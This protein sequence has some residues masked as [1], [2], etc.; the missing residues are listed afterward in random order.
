M[1][2]V[3][4]LNAQEENFKKQGMN[5]EPDAVFAVSMGQE[6]AEVRKSLEQAG[7]EAA[8]DEGINPAHARTIIDAVLA[9]FDTDVKD[10]SDGD[11][12]A[13]DTIDEI[14]GVG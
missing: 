10:V 5:T 2:K 9:K 1:A 8:E 7:L 14:L 13:K 11:P 3:T 12:Y 4:K 6:K